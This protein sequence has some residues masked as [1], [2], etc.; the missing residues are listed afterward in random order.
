MERPCFSIFQL[1]K[2]RP[3]KA[4]AF[5]EVTQLGKT[6]PGQLWWYVPVILELSQLMKE[7]EVSL[8]YTH[9]RKEERKE[10]RD[11]GKMEG[12]KKEKSGFEYQVWSEGSWSGGAGHILLSFSGC[13]GSFTRLGF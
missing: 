13:Q 3:R 9:K 7:F 5:P 10:G 1:R 11:K 8:D 2:L 12:R 6:V 4:T